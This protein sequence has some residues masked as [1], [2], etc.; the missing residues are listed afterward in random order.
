MFKTKMKKLLVIVF[1]ALSIN[2]CSYGEKKHNLK[3]ATEDLSNHYKKLQKL[4][5]KNE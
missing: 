3:G 4:K 1:F 5:S 2:G